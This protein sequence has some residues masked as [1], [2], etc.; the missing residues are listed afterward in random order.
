MAEQGYP[1]FAGS[2]TLKK[3][4]K[5]TANEIENRSFDIAK[6]STTVTKV[7]VNGKDAGDIMWHPY[8]VDLSGLLHEGEN[9][10]EVTLIGNLRNLLGPFHMK[11]GECHSVGPGRFF[12]NS[13]IWVKGVHP[14][15]TDTYCFVECGLFF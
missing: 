2:I 13:P 4:I 6:L 7:K 5:L 1:F 14:N 8:S 11:E 15:W 3:K 9:E 12:H 10:I